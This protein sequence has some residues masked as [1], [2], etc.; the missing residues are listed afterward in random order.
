MDSSSGIGLS[1]EME[2][3]RVEFG[4]DSSV[5]GKPEQGTSEFMPVN[6]NP[7]FFRPP[8]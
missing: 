2:R 4:T 8:H 1:A 5:G 7:S 6:S 3:G